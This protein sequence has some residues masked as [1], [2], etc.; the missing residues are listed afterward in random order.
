MNFA[1]NIQIARE[2]LNWNQS[3]LA[4]EMNEKGWPKYSQMTVART[5]SGARTPRLDEALALAEILG[6]SL[7]SLI[8]VR[9]QFTAIEAQ[10]IDMNNRHRQALKLAEQLTSTLKGSIK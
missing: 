8:H 5:E 7:T 4:R 6:Q 10:T 9:D 2:H 1:H 3:Q